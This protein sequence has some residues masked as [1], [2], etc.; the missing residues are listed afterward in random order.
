MHNFGSSKTHYC[1]MEHK[2]VFD[3]TNKLNTNTLESKC[4]TDLVFEGSQEEI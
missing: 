1:K 4:T 3:N 2:T